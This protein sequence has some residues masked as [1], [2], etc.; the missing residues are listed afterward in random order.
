MQPVP[1]RGAAA[2]IVVWTLHLAAPMLGLWLLI[3][4]PRLDPMVK[5]QPTHFWLVLGTAVVSVG[6]AVAINEAARRRADARLSLVALVYLASAAFL[7]LHAAATPGML[8]PGPNAGFAYATPVGLTIAAVI[9]AISSVDLQAWGGYRWPT[10]RRLP[11]RPRRRRPA[12][13]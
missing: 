5:H 12:G 6:L 3:A 10:C 4:R 1:P 8:L 2:R 9:A 13:R 7:G 11:G